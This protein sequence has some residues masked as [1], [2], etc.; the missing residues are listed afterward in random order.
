MVRPA[1]AQQS[2]PASAADRTAAAGP[3]RGFPAL[4]LDVH[5]DGRAGNATADAGRGPGVTGM[6]GR[7]SDWKLLAVMVASLAAV[8]AVTML[9]KR[10]V[11]TLPP[12]V[13]EVLGEA[14]LGG[15]HAVRIVRFGPKTL[16]VGV[17]AAG[18]HPLA[19]LSD[20][21]ATACI[22]AAC[23]GVHP[24]IRPQPQRAGMP[25]RSPAPVPQRTGGEAA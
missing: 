10:R 16:L 4:P 23:R 7:L 25:Q 22:A 3:P 1:T 14:S 8:A 13:F 15:Q 6:S 17:S 2:A 21:Q 24:P 19:E 9:S 20:P 18:C 12:D 5:T 11:A